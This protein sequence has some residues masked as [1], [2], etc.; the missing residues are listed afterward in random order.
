MY[1][2]SKQYFSKIIKFGIRYDVSVVENHAKKLYRP[3][4]A[5]EVSD[6]RGAV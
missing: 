1:D 4:V 3:E 5:L 2:K 6:I